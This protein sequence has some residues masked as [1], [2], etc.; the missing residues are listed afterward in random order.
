M[1]V[2]AL[3]R[4]R[5]RRLVQAHVDAETA[6][7]LPAIMATFSPTAENYVNQVR[8][9]GLTAIAQGHVTIG[10]SSEPGAFENLRGVTVREYFT[11]AEMLIEGYLEGMFVR[12]LASVLPTNTQIQVPFINVYRFD[13]DGLL[14]LERVILNF[15]ALGGGVVTP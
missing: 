7:D 12:P 5:R 2:D 6:H 10:F 13:V 8:F 15:G 4:E 3:E 9:E 11:E 14:A 1:P